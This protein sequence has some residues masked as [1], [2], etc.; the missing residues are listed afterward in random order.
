MENSRF[1]KVDEKYYISTTST[2]AD[3]RTRVL[4]DSD[5]FGVFD[6]WGDIQPIGQEAQGLYHEGTRFLSALELQLNGKRPLLLSSSIKEENEV[7]SVDLTNPEYSEDEI[8]VHQGM[9]HISRKKFIK[10][11]ACFENIQ[12]TNYDIQDHTLTL[13]IMAD[14]DF[15][16]IFEVRGMKRSKRGKQGTCCMENDTMILSYRGLDKVERKTEITFSPHPDVFSNQQI[17]YRIA[18]TPQQTYHIEYSIQLRTGDQ[19][20]KAISHDEAIRKLTQQLQDTRA[21]ITTVQTSNEQFDHWINRSKTDLVSLLTNTSHGKYPYAGV[22]WYNTAFGR[23]GILTAYEAL[24]V[25]PE[26]ARGVLH[27]VAKT[28]ADIADP[29]RDAEPGKIFHEMRK[30]EMVALNEL[31]FGRY[32]GTVDATPLFIMLAGAYYQRTGDKTTIHD[33]WP[34]IKAALQWIDTYGDTNG[35]GFVE[36]QH[37]SKNGLTNQGWKDSFDSVMYED[38][39]LA[40]PPIAL[41]EVQGYVYAAKIQ[42]ARLALMMGENKLSQQL[43]RE[44][45]TLKRN[46][47]KIFWDKKLQTFVLALDGDQRPCRVKSSNAGQCLFTGIVDRKHTHALTNTLMGEDMFTGWGI[48]TLGI[49]EVR[50]NPM[51]YHNGSVWPHDVALIAYGLSRYGFQEAAQ[52]ITAGLFDATLF[53]DLQRLPELFCGFDRRP[54]EGPTAY[55]VA[56]SPQAWSVAAVFLLLQSLLNLEIDALAQRITFRSPT[57]PSYLEHIRIERLQLGSEHITLEMHRQT[58]D[59]GIQ[60]IDKPKDWEVVICK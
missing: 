9:L 42:A 32:Y 38:G 5:T 1:L 54:G 48:R 12:L 11:G 6:R 50:Y 45:T 4:N 13:V 59:V 58:H 8:V 46:F 36:Y 14:A 47:N 60:I 2:Y 7:L 19:L 53:L 30:G 25:A 31:P 26:I 34:N 3:D 24:W 15:K 29:A 22:P 27:F 37:K 35:D 21:A 23:D 17:E 55:P 18:L 44:A 56:C 20:T 57:L 16:D 52:Q 10:H 39:T 28:Q 33:I 51:S 41:C 49:Q 40:K 43:G